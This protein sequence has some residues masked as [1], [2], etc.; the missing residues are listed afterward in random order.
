MDVFKDYADFYRRFYGGRELWR[1]CGSVRDAFDS[2]GRKIISVLNLRRWVA[3][4]FRQG[5]MCPDLSRPSEITIA[6][7]AVTGYQT[8]GFEDALPP[9]PSRRFNVCVTRVDSN[10]RDG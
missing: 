8:P 3:I 9:S 6:M 7:F 4:R 10:G 1:G 5:I 2:Y